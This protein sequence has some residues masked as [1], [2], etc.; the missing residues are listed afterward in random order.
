MTAWGF[1]ICAHLC[2]L[3]MD[4]KGARM[5]QGDA[6]GRERDPETYAIIG[7]AM[8]V[9]GELGCGFLEPVY[10]QALERELRAQAIPYEREKELPVYYRGERLDAS[11][12]AD[13]ICYGSVIV[14]L[15]ALKQLSGAEEA[16]VLNYLKASGLHRGLLLNFGGRRL[17]YKRFVFNLRAS[18]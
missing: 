3:Q 5:G 6:G 9:H 17:E 13:F 1:G 4:G 11:Y 14:E 2:N 12:R 8:A 10:Q 15:K 7:A 16:Q 18:V